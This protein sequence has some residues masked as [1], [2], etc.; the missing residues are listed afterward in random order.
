MTTLADMILATAEK[1]YVRASMAGKARSPEFYIDIA[2]NYLINDDGTA[3]LEN[4]GRK[5]KVAVDKQKKE[6]SKNDARNRLKAK[7]EAKKAK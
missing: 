3:Y 1:T 4:L 6:D 5:Y 2:I 7:F